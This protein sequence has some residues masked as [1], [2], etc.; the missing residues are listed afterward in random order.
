MARLG[1]RGG[2]REN[3]GVDERKDVQNSVSISVFSPFTIFWD[4][5]TDGAKNSACHCNE[6][7]YAK[8]FDCFLMQKFIFPL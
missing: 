3:R 4:G 7:V 8:N 5:H 1:N 6:L 2:L